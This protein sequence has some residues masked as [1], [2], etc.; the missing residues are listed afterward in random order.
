MDMSAA[1]RAAVAKNPPWAKIVFDKLYV[2][3][4]AYK[5]LDDHRIVVSRD[6]DMKS[7]RRWAIM[8]VKNQLISDLL[9]ND[10]VIGLYR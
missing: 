8:S 10:P 3:K 7:V 4:M 5:A 2:V 6:A 1:Y 9:C